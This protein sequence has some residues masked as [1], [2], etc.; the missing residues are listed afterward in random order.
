MSSASFQNKF[1]YSW[2]VHV[3]FMNSSE[4]NDNFNWYSWRSESIRSRS[5]SRKIEISR[6]RSRMLGLPT[7]QSFL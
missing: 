1:P 5:W 7:P 6:C 2:K 3:G 4:M